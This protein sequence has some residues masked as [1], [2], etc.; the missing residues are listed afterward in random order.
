MGVSYWPVV[1]DNMVDLS[2]S[3]R[4]RGAPPGWALLSVAL[5]APHPSLDFADGQGARQG[6]GIW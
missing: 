6:R 2:I 5:A 4:D 1:A 3:G